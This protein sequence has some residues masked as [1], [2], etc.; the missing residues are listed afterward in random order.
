MFLGYRGINGSIHHLGVVVHGDDDRE[1]H[2]LKVP[3]SSTVHRRHA[4]LLLPRWTTRS[5]CRTNCATLCSVAA[6]SEWSCVA[7]GGIPSDPLV[8]HALCARALPERVEFR[9]G[10]CDSCGSL[11]LLDG[12][13]PSPWYENYERHRING[14]GPGR[15]RITR[16]IGRV[17]ALAAP[18]LTALPARWLPPHPTWLA[19]MR[20]RRI[21]MHMPILDVGCGQGAQLLHLHRFGFD[22]LLGIDPYLPIDREEFHDGEVVLRQCGLDEVAS[23]GFGLIGFFHSLEHVDDPL[24][25]LLEARKCL[26]KSGTVVVELPIVGGRAW[27]RFR[28]HWPGLDTPLH[29]WL[30]S[31]RG[32]ALLAA[33]A[34]FRLLRWRGDS[35]PY[36]YEQGL[37]I[38]NGCA[39]P[40]FKATE[41]LSDREISWCRAMA[42][43]D[44]GGNG[45]Q[46]SFVLTPL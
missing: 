30:P 36:Y 2:R 22:N 19:Q 20:G 15:T 14:G 1:V 37:M 11:T 17:G 44:R 7:C 23:D 33:R 4:T 12:V 24:A 3:G 34:G 27:S 10:E 40:A 13:D 18:R 43:S 25:M 16:M 35:V 39:P 42:R 38:R 46:G 41:V 9:W 21:D 26:G 29:R 32:M 8:F 31:P 6:P 28:D 5:R 45:S